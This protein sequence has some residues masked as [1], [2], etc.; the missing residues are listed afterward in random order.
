MRKVYVVAAK[1]TA[2]GSMLGSL[3]NIDATDFGAEVVKALLAETKVEGKDVSEVIV[4]NVLSAG[5]G[6]GPGRQVAVKAGV[7]VEVPAYSV[8]MLCGSG[9]KSIMTGFTAI[10]DGFDEI[11]IAGG[12]ESMSRAPHLVPSSIRGGVKMGDFKLTDHMIYDALTDAY[13]QV[14]MGVTAENI[15]KKFGITRQEQDEFAYASQVKAIKAVDDG[16]FDGEIVPIVIKDRKG[17]IIFN[18]D[19]YPNRTTNLEKLAALRPAFVKDGSVTAGNSSGI[20]DGAAFVMLMSEEAVKKYN[21]KPLAEI[22][23]IGQGGVDPQYMGLG[24]VAAIGDVMKRS[25]Y[26]LR[27]MEVVE[28]NEAFA[29]QSLG[30]LKNLVEE[31]G[32]NLVELLKKTNIQGGAIAL[33]HPVG[34]SGARI[35]VTL[36]H[37]MQRHDHKVG[38][39]SLCIG[40]GMG[41]AVILKRI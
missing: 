26:K 2:T 27:D 19:E 39:A 34:A 37:I 14:H 15:A 11:V 7:P 21:L 22:V 33:G 3:K 20:N 35:L 6:Q 13:S 28:L 9:M 18:R 16:S 36:L 24:P 12:I 32:G 10:R 25:G 41:T 4:G 38:L 31:H 30:V 29:A 40:G 8:N 17:D 1:R 23:G 5:L